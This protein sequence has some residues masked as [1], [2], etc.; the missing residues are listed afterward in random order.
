MTCSITHV[1]N[2]LLVSFLKQLNPLLVNSF[3]V[4]SYCSFV[5]NDIIVIFFVLL[6]TELRLIGL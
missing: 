3:H 4:R 6:E 5:D 1:A 2:P